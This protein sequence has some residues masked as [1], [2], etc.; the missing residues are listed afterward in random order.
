MLLN[1]GFPAASVDSVFYDSM[2]AKAIL[3]L[4]EQYKWAQINTDSIEQD[5]LASIGWNEK[6]FDNKKM[7]FNRLEVQQERIFNYYE[8]S[9]YPFA[10][11]SL[12]TLI[13]QPIKLKAICE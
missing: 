8:N 2:S 9:G 6:Q 1:K 7:D 10:E 13:Y 4:G 12:K 5:A 3:F 11:V